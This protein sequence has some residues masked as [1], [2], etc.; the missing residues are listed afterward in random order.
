MSAAET[1]VFSI[2]ACPPHRRKTDPLSTTIANGWDKVLETVNVD[3]CHNGREDAAILARREMRQAR[4]R[5]EM[6]RD[7]E[8]AIFHV[9]IEAQRQTQRSQSSPLPR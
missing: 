6:N 7:L 9:A 3:C 4:G 2:I 1:R 5:M 8:A